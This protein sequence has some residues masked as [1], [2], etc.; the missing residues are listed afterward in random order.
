MADPELPRETAP[1]AAPQSAPE[2]APGIR[3]GRGPGIRPEL[4]PGIPAL[5]VVIPAYDASRFLPHALAALAGARVPVLVV[6]DASRDDTAAC[7]EAHGA[8]VLRLPHRQGPAAARNAGAQALAA[9]VVLFLD[10]DC[11]A[12]PAVPARV[13]A[14]FARDPGLVGLSGS[15][16]AHPPERNFASL[17]MNLRHHHTHQIAP[18]D[19]RSF[20]AGCGAVRRAAFLAAG[21]FDARRFPAPAIEDIE[22]AVRLGRHGRLRF[23]RALQATHR[24]RWGLA[25]LV[26][27]EIR[28]RAIPWARLV[29]GSPEAP[30]GL[31]L[32]PS[33]RAAALLAPIAL[34]ALPA[35]AWA[36]ARGH[37]GMAAASVAVLAAAWASNASLFACFAR[38]G[39]PRFAAAAFL[40]H[41]L[42]LVYAGA[43]F[44]L[45]L[46]AE[47]GRLR[48]RAAP[49][50]AAS[51]PVKESATEQ[52]AVAG[53][54]D[55]R[56]DDEPDRD[57][58]RRSNAADGLPPQAMRPSRLLHRLSGA[59]HE[60]RRE[61][62]GERE[63]E[64]GEGE[65]RP[66]AP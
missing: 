37:S 6:D 40:F 48:R 26:D 47:R 20:W 25:S 15:Y 51:E 56:R 45:A 28:R 50:R 7:A 19:T 1:G 49:E 65:R 10:A 52:R 63:R 12:H 16:D 18:P 58:A 38:H 31:N 53:R 42:H 22:L 44:A 36:L 21:G 59:Q 4:D 17:Y 2:G 24:K 14:A 55:A 23:D 43:A 61:D 3:S 66:A 13:R 5:A 41:Q 11:V 46:A 8:R 39:G 62:G 27:T 34:A 57:R 30:R 9:E 35:L 60:A 54:P 33:Q 32:R 64:P 29:A